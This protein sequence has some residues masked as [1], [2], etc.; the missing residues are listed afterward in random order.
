VSNTIRLGARLR[1]A[2]RSAGFKTS[3]SFLNKHKVAASTYS[4]HESGA[5]T[6]DDK[7]LL[8]Y[9]KIFDVNLDWLK[10]GKGSPF[11]ISTVKKNSVMQEELL[12]IKQMKQSEK[13]SPT[14]IHQKILSIIL[15]DMIKIH[16]PTNCKLPTTRIVR[17]ALALY[18]DVIDI[19][20]SKIQRNTIN[21][22]LKKY[23]SKKLKILG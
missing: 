7:M 4:Q 1:A 12:D 2:R 19:G 17:D 16:T 5:R 3:K 10:H 8:F 22:R 23:K 11:R 13:P 14:T 15:E 6:P 21:I 9:A 20:D 18:M